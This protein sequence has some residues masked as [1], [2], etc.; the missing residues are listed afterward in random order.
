M[1]LR[2]SK[3]NNIEELVLDMRYNGGG[4]LTIA[5]EL[6]YMVAG[7]ASEGEVFDALTFNDKYTVRDP[8]NNNILE[9]SRFSSTAAGFDAPI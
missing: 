2:S 6:G 1:P 8:I 9:P 3:R 4:Y 7:S 5:A